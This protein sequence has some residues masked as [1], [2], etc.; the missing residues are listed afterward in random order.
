VKR[1]EF[2][3]LAGSA[4]AAWQHSASAQQAG[5][6]V[7]GYLGVSSQ[8]RSQRF[9][10]AF[11]SGLKET[12]FIEGQNLAIEYRRAEDRYDRLP[13]LAA[14]LV[15]RQVTVIV[16]FTH[17]A[18]VAA[19]AATTTI[20]IAFTTARDPVATGLVA[21]LNRPGGNMTG[22]TFL[23]AELWAKGLGLLHE[24]VPNAKTI[25]VLVNPDNPN[26]EPQVQQVQEVARKLG[27]QVH[28]LS[29]RRNVEFDAI[30]ASVVKQRA[31]ALVVTTDPL[32][33]TNRDQ[34]IALATR[35][36]IPTVFSLREFSVAGG[37]LSYGADLADGYRQVGVYIAKILQ[38][39]TPTDLPIIQP[40]K[41][42]FVL[43]L[44]TA[45]TLGLTVPFGVLAIAD[46]VIE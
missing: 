14:D 9:D 21:S 17:L 19:K 22:A 46:E 36:S 24:L 25:T 6:P 15:H 1:R 34:L 31:D 4:A 20:P 43:N 26:A 45:K 29:A 5:K 11:L 23:G 3:T 41:F 8:I 32:L 40:T 7:I 42:E 30:F 18:A 13:A 33:I 12:G 37:L 35:Y 28:V 39:T 2:I 16:A 38:G 27:L 10:A 44:K